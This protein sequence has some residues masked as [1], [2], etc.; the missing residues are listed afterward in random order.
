MNGVMSVR[1][2]FEDLFIFGVTEDS[3]DVRFGDV[4]CARPSHTKGRA[5]GEKFCGMALRQ[6]AQAVVVPESVSDLQ[7]DLSEYELSKAVIIRV[8]S[9]PDFLAKLVGAFYTH[10]PEVLAAI[11]GTNGKTSTASF[12]KDIWNACGVNA[13][14]LGTLG[15][16]GCEGIRTNLDRVMTTFDAKSL[17]LVMQRLIIDHEVKNIV[18]EASSHALD[19]ERL[20]GVEFDVVA[21]TNLTQD[22]LDYHGSMSSYGDAKLKLFGERLRRG[23]TSIVNIDDPF[24]P[25]VIAAS[26]ARGA[27]IVTFSTLGSDADLKLVDFQA[28]PMGLRMTIDLFGR[29]RSIEVPVA[30]KF[31]I[32]NLLCAIGIAHSSN[33]SLDR[34][35]DKIL[36]LS[37][38]RGRLEMVA[39]LE[40]GA[41]IFVDYAHTEDALAKVLSS[42]K[43]HISDGS[44]LSVLFGCGGSKDVTKRPKMGAAAAKYADRIYVT[45]DNP[46][47]E[48]P[49]TIRRQIMSAA[50][51]NAIDAG[52]R[53]VAIEKAVGELESGDILVVA[54]KGHEDYQIVSELNGIDA[55]GNETGTR[56]LLFDDAAI[57]R[58][59]IGYS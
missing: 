57:V 23:G 55:D 42:L 4:F 14:A 56:K 45:D 52:E 32:E 33:L 25:Q 47:T 40:N 17:H 34:I 22:H 51:S 38:V 9:V 7:L 8:S 1:G 50:G 35:I 20:S 28:L 53:R 44:K 49:E 11:T 54:G 10:R 15:V 21:F 24:S 36:T 6:G 5:G 16:S 43:P 59:I 26:T 37:P 13:A 12:V 18:L 19:Q 27:S 29:R 30:G 39:A 31:Q 58:E 41:T 2:E 46:R 3:R 48:D